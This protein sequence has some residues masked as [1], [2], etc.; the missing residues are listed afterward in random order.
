[1]DENLRLEKVRK[2]GTWYLHF[3]WSCH[4]FLSMFRIVFF[5]VTVAVVVVLPVMLLVQPWQTVDPRL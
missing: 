5:F 3:S 1:M 4:I 2:I